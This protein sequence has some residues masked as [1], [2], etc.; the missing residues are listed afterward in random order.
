VTEVLTWNYEAKVGNQII[1]LSAWHRPLCLFAAGANKQDYS[2]SDTSEYLG[3]GE[4]TATPK[5]PYLDL[6]YCNYVRGLFKPGIPCLLFRRKAWRGFVLALEG[7]GGLACP[8]VQCA[9]MRVRSGLLG[10]PCLEVR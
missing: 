1:M 3:I 5:L 2:A 6:K 10:C 8:G 9:L 4:G 7:F